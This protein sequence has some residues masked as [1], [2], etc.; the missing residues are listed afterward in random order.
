MIGLSNYLRLL[1]LK[2]LWG[3]FGLVYGVPNHHE[4]VVLWIGSFAERGTER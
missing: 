1:Q 2:P 3:N 4:G